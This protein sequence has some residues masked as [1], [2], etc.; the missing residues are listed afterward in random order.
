MNIIS[1][2]G[3]SKKIQ[4]N[5]ATTILPFFGCCVNNKFTKTEIVYNSVTSLRLTFDANRSRIGKQGSDTNE[6][7]AYFHAIR[8]SRDPHRLNS[9]LGIC[10]LG[11]IPVRS[12][13]DSHRDAYGRTER[14]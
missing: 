7:E 3:A 8:D 14:H 9:S 1:P 5:F 13:H 12:R 6:E 11:S 10:L 2:P 4:F